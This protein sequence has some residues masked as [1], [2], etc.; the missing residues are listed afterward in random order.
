MNLSYRRSMRA[1]ERE[2]IRLSILC[3]T[4]TSINRVR[5]QQ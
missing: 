4:P 5:E 3:G 2:T 1:D